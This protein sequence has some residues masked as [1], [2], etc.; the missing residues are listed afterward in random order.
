[1]FEEI[2]L[3]VVSAGLLLDEDTSLKTLNTPD[4]KPDYTPSSDLQKKITGNMVSTTTECEECGFE[5]DLDLCE[6]RPNQPF[7]FHIPESDVSPVD[8]AER[9]PLTFR[10]WK[11]F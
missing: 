6:T 2:N 11:I 10:K 7:P 3:A 4:V 9:D 8:L 5:L 1:M